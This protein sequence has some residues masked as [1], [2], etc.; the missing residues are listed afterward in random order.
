MMTGLHMSKSLKFKEMV[1]SQML[2]K[3][4]KIS[5]VNVCRTDVN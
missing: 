2:F 5:K 4:R 1:R 3:H